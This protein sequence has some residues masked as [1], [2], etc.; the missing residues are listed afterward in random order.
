M[1][2]IVH[3]VGTRPNFMKAAPVLE[4]CAKKGFVQ[5]LVH[6]GQHYDAQM[7][8]VFFQ[9][10]GL[11]HPDVNLEVGPGSHAQ[12]TAQVMVRFEKFVSQTRPDMVLVYGD[13][14]STLAAALVCAKMLIPLAHVE[15]GLRSFDKTMPEEINRI[16][17]DHIGDYL[18]TTCVDADKN[19]LKEGVSQEKIFFVGNVMIDTLV[20]LKPVAQKSSIVESLG[21]CEKKYVLATLHRPSNVDDSQRLRGLIGSLERIGSVAPVI[22]PV[23]PRTRQRIEAL[24]YA[25]DP[26]QLMLVDPLGYVDFIKLQID[27]AAVITDSGGVQEE[28]TFLGIPCLTLRPNTERPVTITQGTNQLV[29]EDCKAL[30]Q[31][32]QSVL[33]G[34]KRVGTIPALWD[35]KAAQRIADILGEL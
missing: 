25:F 23:H 33:N 17:V 31:K 26:K 35:G 20:K 13:V 22:F 10:L 21:L 19:L 24:D 3:V 30:E 29:G 9:Q 1:M 7:S 11:P 5:S 6:T 32:T 18:F 12:Q 27:A 34:K 28:T 8:E 15:A 4:A 16:V 2:H 14:N